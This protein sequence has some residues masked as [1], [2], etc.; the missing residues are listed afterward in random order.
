MLCRQRSELLRDSTRYKNHLTALLDQIF[1]GF[2]RV[3]SKVSGKGSLAALSVCPTPQAVLRTELARLAEAIS[4]G[5]RKPKAY[6]VE[7][8]QKIRDA[9][10][11]AS[12]IGIVSS[13]DAAAVATATGMLKA[14]QQT[15]DSLEEEIKSLAA[16]NAE[17]IKNVELLSSIPGIGFWISMVLV[18]EIVGLSNI[19]D[20]KGR[21]DISG[22]S[23][24][25]RTH[26]AGV[27]ATLVGS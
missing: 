25:K 19:L 14:I 16:K 17:I 3:F 10:L 6:G 12:T 22:S 4:E 1:P 26:G 23:P 18:S 2:D 8:A 7:K 20:S 15:L 13:G 11:H 24:V 21:E 5:S 9:A 27:A